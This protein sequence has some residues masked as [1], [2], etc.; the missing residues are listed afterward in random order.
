MTNEQWKL[1]EPQWHGL[2]VIELFVLR[3][4][5]LSHKRNSKGFD[6]SN[7]RAATSSHDE[8]SQTHIS[9]TRNRVRL[10]RNSFG[11]NDDQ[12]GG[13]DLSVSDL[14]EMV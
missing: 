12:R 13:R 6:R 7:R 1:T 3:F 11:A 5:A 2:F 10:K 14:L 4:F 8:T 9:W